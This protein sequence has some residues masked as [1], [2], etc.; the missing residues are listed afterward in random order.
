MSVN[1]TPMLEQ[2]HRIKRDHRDAI[3][4]FRMGDFYEMFFDDAQTAS[5]ILEIAL[6]ARGRGTDNEA[7]MCG[8]PHHSV[9]A[10]IARLIANGHKVAVC[11]QVEDAASAKGLVRRE[12]VRVVSPGTVTDPASLDATEN[13]Y[14][15]CLLPADRGVGAACIDLSTGEFRLLQAEGDRA[16]EQISLQ[17]S[18]FRPREILQP[19]AAGCASLLDRELSTGVTFTDLETWAFGRDAAYQSLTEQM[20]TRSLEGFGCE[21]MDLGVRAGGALLHHLRCTQRSSLDHIRRVLPHSAADHMLLDGAT[22][23]T[24]EVCRSLATGG[25]AGSLLSVLDRTVT[26]MGARRL[27]AWLL[28]PPLDVDRTTA[29]LDAVEE[30][31]AQTRRRDELRLLMKGIRDIERLLGRVTLGTA[32]ARDVLSLRDSLAPLP[33]VSAVASLLSSPMLSGSPGPL[34]SL[35]TSGPPAALDALEDLHDLLARSIADE[36]AATLH[37]GGMIRAGY[38]VELDDLRAISKDATSYLASLETRERARSGIASLKVR[39]NKVFGYYIEVSKANLALAPADY[40]RKQTLVNAERFVTPEL[41]QY[42]EKILTAQER[43]QAVE[44]DLFHQVR[45][46]VASQ[47]ARLKAA[48]DRLADLD[49]L[50][51][52]AEVAVARGYTRPLVTDGGRTRISAG[53]H[54]VVE[55]LNTRERFVPNDVE[56]SGDGA[57]ILIV[58]GPNMGGKST[59]L[60]QAALITLMAQMG[61]FVPA[62]RAEIGLVDRIFSRIGSSDNLAGGQ[63]TFMVEMQETAN[64]LNNAT[65]RSLILLDEVGRGTSTFDGLSLAWAIAEHLHEAS[66][67]ADRGARVLFATHYHELTEMALTMPGIR[68]LTVSVK[69]SGQDVIFLRRIVEG[70]ADRSYGIQVARLA[71]LPS[72]VIERAREVLA[73]LETNEFGRDGMPKLARHGTPRSARAPNHAGQLNLFWPPED[74]GVTEVIRQIRRLEPETVTPLEALRLLS[75]MKERLGSEE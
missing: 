65:D 10:Y 39:Y 4:M 24:L 70:A 3:L 11:D 67:R 34:A 73:N 27:Q 74:P 41:K 35:D 26:P 9:D 1:L 61:S 63:S 37:E 38:S 25:R 15:G 48:S 52:L 18:A 7:P 69:E 49:T 6:T 58:T 55:I 22:L 20:G 71:G 5:R 2:Y 21:Q 47:A 45:D 54:P 46:E 60:R 14:I 16:W 44:L 62:R 53:R 66:A 56:M 64:I 8:V 28:S 42:E 36:P 51:S 57:R 32:T 19:E 68:N 33:Q 29:R 30:L 72:S 23:R 50:A 12:V 43:I 75:A 59:Y 40:E 31:A 13:L 17:L